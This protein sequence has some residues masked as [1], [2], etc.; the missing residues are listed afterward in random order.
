MNDLNLAFYEKLG[1]D[2][3]KELAIKGGFHS[4]IDLE[5]AF[6]YIKDSKTILELGAGYGRCL[7]FFLEKNFN[8]KLIAVE[9]SKP[10]LSHLSVKY[11]TEIQENK[12]EVIAKDIKTI[13]LSERADAALWMWSG[14]IDFAPEEQANAIKNIYD[15]LNPHGRLIIDI[16]RLGYQTYAQHIDSQHLRFDSPYGP[17]NCY[18]PSLKDIQMYCSFAGFSKIINLDYN[19]TTEKQRTLYILEK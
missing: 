15:S 19:T 8:G 18:I 9:L 10:L 5:L 7:D 6:P 11:A 17:L 14:I 1:V 4:Y 12:I 3:F 2:P 16:P 13:S